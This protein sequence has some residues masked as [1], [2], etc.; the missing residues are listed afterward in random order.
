MCFS[1]FWT[2]GFWRATVLTTL[3]IKDHSE[4]RTLKNHA[5][6]ESGCLMCTVVILFVDYIPGYNFC[7][8]LKVQP[9]RGLAWLFSPISIR[10]SSRPWTLK[11]LRRS[12][13][14]IDPLFPQWTRLSFLT[15]PRVRFKLSRSDSWPVRHSMC[16]SPVKTLKWVS[17]TWMSEN[18]TSPKSEFVQ[19]L[20]TL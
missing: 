11:D 4:S 5:S 12:T 3:G 13:Y 16:Q 19:N 20:E 9:I 15:L 18:R 8:P 7:N 6:L 17:E 10:S 1:R 2:F 14:G